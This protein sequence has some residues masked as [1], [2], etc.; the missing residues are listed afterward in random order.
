MRIFSEDEVK[1]IKDFKKTDEQ[2][3]VAEKAFCYKDSKLQKALVD[4]CQDNVSPRTVSKYFIYSQ[5]ERPEFCYLNHQKQC[6]TFDFDDDR[7]DGRDKL[8]YLA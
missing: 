1:Y 2:T 3:R 8:V 7:P 5:N 6:L 4:L